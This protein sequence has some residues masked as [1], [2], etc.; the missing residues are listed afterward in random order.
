M[1]NDVA[2]DPL[3]IGQLATREQRIAQLEDRFHQHRDGDGVPVLG[4]EE[5]LVVAEL[6]DELNAITNPD[7]VTRDPWG[8]LARLMAMRIYDRLGI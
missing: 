5:L 1:T 4:E 2:S 3:N 8:R 7:G 6:L